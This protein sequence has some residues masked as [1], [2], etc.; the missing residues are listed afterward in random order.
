MAKLT[1]K[2]YKRKKVA[3]AAILLGGVALVSS[4]FA[5]WVLSNDT[6]GDATGNVTVG[7][8]VDNNLSMTVALKGSD[9]KNSGVFSFDAAKDDNGGRV[10][11]NG[12]DY[13]NLSLTYTV[14][15]TSKT[16]NLNKLT[17][18]M[19]ETEST[20]NSDKTTKVS[21]KVSTA[22]T[23]KWIVAP[24]CMAN[25]TEIT[26]GN[27]TGDTDKGY[28]WTV[29]YEVAFTWGTAFGSENPS[30]FFDD[31]EKTDGASESPK[32]GTDYTME[33]VTAIL[34]NLHTVLDGA[35]FKL[36]FAATAK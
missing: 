25:V 9:S 3:F 12:T 18:K 5:A 35:T 10:R 13:A 34:Q 29:D 24:T 36:D 28:T 17:V 26:V 33:E 31:S 8:I 1:R 6:K 32:K 27:P 23:N 22:V 19:T 4:G 11:S 14:T 21:N 15:I 7:E 16:N 30:L 2:S 20:N